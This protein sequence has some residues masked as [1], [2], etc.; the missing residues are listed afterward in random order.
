MTGPSCGPWTIPWPSSKTIRWCCSD[1]HAGT[2]PRTIELATPL[3]RILAVGSHLK[4]TVAL[5]L[6]DQVLLSP[7]IGDLDGPEGLH[8][9][10]RT[11]RDLLAFLEYTPEAV[12][13]DLHPDY[14]SRPQAVAW[15]ERFNVPLLEVQHHH[16]HV[17]AA[18][19]EHRLTGPVLGLAWDGT[20][21]GPDHTVWGGEALRCEGEIFTRVAH[22]RTFP[23][24]GG[25]RAVEEPR[26]AAFGLLHALDPDRARAEALA[27]F[28]PVERDVLA[29][30]IDRGLNAPLTSGMGR[31][32]DA[33]AAILGLFPTRSFEGEAAMGVEF[34]ADIEAG[35]EP[36]PLP[37]TTGEPAV[38]D[39]APLVEALLADR[40]RGV[41]LARISGRFHRALAEHAVDVARHA[42]LDRV[43]LTGGCFQNRTL[44]RLVRGRLEE[45][46]F[47]VYTHHKVP[48]NDG[49]LSLGQVWVAGHRLASRR[50]S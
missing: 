29:R 38:A 33:V 22:L 3:P 23:L 6:G 14:G 25:E 10:D 19:A 50:T 12:A 45:A 48:P 47:R 40:D 46:G 41:D 28:T 13:C 15:A 1:A 31:L 27:W 44:T 5:G 21:H 37:L 17:A 11:L 2:P 42:G 26:R 43:V 9:L 8:V 7:H 36:Y 20:G 30:M 35:H 24:P 4:N 32:F 34:V 39:W 49:G 18:A 16:A